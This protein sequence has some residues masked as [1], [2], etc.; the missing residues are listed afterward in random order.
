MDDRL[1]RPRA[2]DDDEASRRRR[3]LLRRRGGWYDLAR[4]PITQRPFDTGECLVGG[5]VAHDRRHGVVRQVVGPVEL[6]Q[7]VAGDGADRCRHPPLRH[8]VRMEAVDQPVEHDAGDVGRIVVVHLEARQDAAAD[9]LDLLIRERRMPRHVGHQVESEVEAVLHHQDVDEAQLARGADRQDAADAVYRV[10]D[11]LGGARPR[12]LIEELPDKR[13]HAR[14]AGRVGR[15][16]SLQDHPDADRRLLVVAHI[17]NVEAV[18]QRPDLI[19]GK[20]HVAADQ[21]RWRLLARPVDPLRGGRGRQRERH[22]HNRRD[23]RR[24]AAPHRP[25]PLPRGRIVSTSRVSSRR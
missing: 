13:G 20:N 5:H 16:A 21:R 3:D 22:G 7:V 14:L 23:R 9:P 1:D 10:G 11:R 12:A 25:P 4:F 8:P 17:D 6:H 19:V 24:K 15:R 2:V 18:R